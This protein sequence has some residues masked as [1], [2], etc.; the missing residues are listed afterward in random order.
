MKAMEA[1]SVFPT[2]R[3]GVY[4]R[5]RV[6][7]CAI[8]AAIPACALDL[9][10]SSIAFT[11]LPADSNP[12][13]LRISR[14]VRVTPGTGYSEVIAAGSLWQQV[15]ET[16]RGDVY[17]LVGDVFSLEGANRHEAYLIVSEREFVGFYLPG[18]RAYAPLPK[19]IPLPVR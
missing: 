16:P 8:L 15:G 4:R 7:L 10:R 11:P 6:L 18:E 5:T 9:E 12:A 14:E 1:T 19:P 13:P 2:G 17:R 3:P